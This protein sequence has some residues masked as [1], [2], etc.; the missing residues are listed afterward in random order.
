MKTILGNCLDWRAQ[1]IGRLALQKE[2]SDLVV[3][4]W[5]AGLAMVS[6][7]IFRHAGDYRS[8]L[9]V[10]VSALAFETRDLAASA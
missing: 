8:F 2:K 3:C 1:N 10:L 5:K 9:I 6:A 7:A 4:N